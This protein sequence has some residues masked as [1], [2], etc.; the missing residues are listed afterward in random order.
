MKVKREE[1]N[2]AFTVITVKP[3][4]DELWAAYVSIIREKYDPRTGEPINRALIRYSQV[5]VTAQTAREFA[6]AILRACDI[7]EGLE[8][9]GDI[10]LEGESEGEQYDRR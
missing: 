1:D 6:Q 8:R 3:W 5:G 10:V 9:D 7:A 2:R 4:P